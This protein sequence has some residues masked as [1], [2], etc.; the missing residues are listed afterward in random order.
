MS[1]QAGM[2]LKYWSFEMVNTG[3]EM[4]PKDTILCLDNSEAI[5][6]GIEPFEVN[7]TPAEP[8]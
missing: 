6:Q 8:G 7:V 3:T 5:H 1:M 4:W 2:E